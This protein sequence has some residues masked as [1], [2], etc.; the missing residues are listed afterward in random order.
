MDQSETLARRVAELRQERGWS[1]ERLGERTGLT[2]SHIRSI[3]S[4][5]CVPGPIALKRLGRALGADVDVL[6][7]IR[8]QDDRRRLPAPFR[9][10]VEGSS[11]P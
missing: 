5:G 3:E 1:V 11:I 8:E 9:Q 6:M 2:T 4:G 7:A 10:L